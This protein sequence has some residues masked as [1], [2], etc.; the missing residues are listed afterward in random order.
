MMGWNV[1]KLVV[2]EW[3]SEGKRGKRPPPPEEQS[4][5]EG[6]EEMPK[7]AFEDY[8]KEKYEGII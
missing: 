2:D 4:H 5:E 3:M 8:L 7:I 1:A 6:G